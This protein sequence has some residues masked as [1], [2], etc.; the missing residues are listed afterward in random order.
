MNIA[1]KISGPAVPKT[2]PEM[3]SGKAP[4]E[5][6]GLLRIDILLNPSTP[7]SQSFTESFKY[8]EFMIN[9]A[10]FLIIILPFKTTH[11]NIIS[12]LYNTNGEQLSL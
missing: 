2:V 7:C 6:K 8:S 10:S 11:Q 5:N 4:E 3:C 12:T 1:S 9:I